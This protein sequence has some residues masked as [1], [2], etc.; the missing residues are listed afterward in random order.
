M[1]EYNE[2]E[3]IGSEDDIFNRMSQENLLSLQNSQN[4][5]SQSH[6]ETLIAIE[7]IN[8]SRD[9]IKNTI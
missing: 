8:Q 3:R 7:R 1:T 4:F 9:S 5:A 6:E 2:E